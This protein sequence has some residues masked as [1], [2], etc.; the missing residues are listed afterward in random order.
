VLVTA[1]RQ[2]GRT[3]LS[4]GFV[5]D[6]RDIARQ[7]ITDLAPYAHKGIAVVGQEPSEILTLRDEYLDLCP[8]DQLDDARTLAAQSC[9]FEEFV[10]QHLRTNPQDAGVF[11]GRNRSV[12]VHGHCHAKSLVGMDPVM[13]VLAEAGYL[14]ENLQTGCCG[15]AG[16]FGYEADHFAV[17]MQVGEQT[18]FPKLRA[19]EEDA[20][21]CAHGFSCRHQ[22][23]DGVQRKSH[24]TAVLLRNALR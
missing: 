18:L 12:L 11:D 10:L 15:M 1:P 6:A 5:R 24:H 21:I 7:T 19:R 16:S 4:K 2:S 14:P 22:I 3:H 8:D 9:M 17:S 23:A 20:L 13:D